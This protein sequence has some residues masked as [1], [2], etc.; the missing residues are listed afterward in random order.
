LLD[1]LGLPAAPLARVEHANVN[2]VFFCP[3]GLV[4]RIAQR[5]ELDDRLGR[6][7]ALLRRLRGKLPVADI[8]T[9]GRFEGHEFQ[10]QRRMAGEPLVFVW[11]H[12]TGAARDSSVSDILRWLDIMRSDT[13]PTFGRIG[14]PDRQF[15]SW[16]DFCQS[17]IALRMDRL[18]HAV[19][20]ELG[21]DLLTDIV[22]FSAAHLATYERGRPA[23]LVHNDLWPANILVRDG[24]VSHLLDFELAVSGAAEADLFTLEY[25][26]RKPEEFG[27]SGQYTDLW[28]RLLRQRPALVAM[29]N[30]RRRFD[31]YD[32]SLTLALWLRSGDLSPE[33]L[34]KMKAHLKEIVSGKI[35]RLL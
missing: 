35:E 3:G 26:C 21:S 22:R 10:V 13:F 9:Y 4:L 2:D 23:C 31:V 20:A 12:M 7:V 6:E 15:S 33:G 32:I 29:P 25:F 27:H 24:A 14:V 11:S 17:D 19:A 16:S 8:V 30:I 34:E 5:A 18:P 28:E 1:H